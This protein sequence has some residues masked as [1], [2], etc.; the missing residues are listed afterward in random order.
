MW[1]RAAERASTIVTL[2]GS[3]AWCSSGLRSQCYTPSAKTL[4]IFWGEVTEFYP[5]TPNP[6]Q[7]ISDYL[8]CML[9]S[10]WLQTWLCFWIFVYYSNLEHHLNYAQKEIWCNLKDP[11]CLLSWYYF[12]ECPTWGFI[13]LQISNNLQ[14]TLNSGD[15]QCNQ[16]AH[17]PPT[18]TLKSY[19]YCIHR[20]SLCGSYETHIRRN[21]CLHQSN[22]ITWILFL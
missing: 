10:V 1:F 12:R 9:A 2:T 17:S 15:I 16:I 21:I 18:L 11:F 22:F 20:C 5:A 14:F 3:G 7:C 4:H 8:G 19:V 13:V 6:F